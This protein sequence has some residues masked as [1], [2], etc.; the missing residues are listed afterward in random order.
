MAMANTDNEDIFAL[1]NEVHNKMRLERVETDRRR[2]LK[3]FWGSSGIFGQKLENLL[4]LLM[5]SIRLDYPKMFN[6][7]YVYLQYI[8]FSLPADGVS[9]A[10]SGFADLVV[11][12][13]T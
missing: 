8:V 7:F 12:R 13:I 1:V 2:D 9:H 3:A 11:Y 10:R 4:E 6:A 5:I